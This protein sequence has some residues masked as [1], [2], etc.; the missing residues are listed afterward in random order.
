MDTPI[1]IVSTLAP[2]IAPPIVLPYVSHQAF[3][4]PTMSKSRFLHL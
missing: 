1:D 2:D 3:D 4:D